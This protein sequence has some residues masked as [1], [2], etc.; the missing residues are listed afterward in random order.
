M[1][2]GTLEPVEQSRMRPA[3]A[4]DEFPEVALDD[5]LFYDPDLL[6]R[7]IQVVFCK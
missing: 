7:R 4:L 6:K 1:T 3:P 2:D 5:A